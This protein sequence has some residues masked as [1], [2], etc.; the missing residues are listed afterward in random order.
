MDGPGSAFLRRRGAT[1]SRNLERNMAQ[2]QASEDTR[3]RPVS[4]RRGKGWMFQTVFAVA[5]VSVS[6]M[7][8]ILMFMLSHS[9]AIFRR[10]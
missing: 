9:E 7:F 8:A 5:S 6:V 4:A 3:N 10:S 2:D 1:T